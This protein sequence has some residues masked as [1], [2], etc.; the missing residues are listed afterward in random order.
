ME[1]KNLKR[2]GF[3]NCSTEHKLILTHF[4]EN[5]KFLKKLPF[6]E[7]VFHILNRN[8]PQGMKVWP[9]GSRDINPFDYLKCGVSRRDINSSCHKKTVPDHQHHGGL[10]QHPQ[11]GRQ[12][13][14]PMVLAKAGGG[15][16]YQERFYTIKAESILN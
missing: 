9:P 8:L 7:T 1:N 14:L 6:I 16:W 2:K 3:E 10:Q 12:E 11:G 5:L 13:R 4:G 15:H